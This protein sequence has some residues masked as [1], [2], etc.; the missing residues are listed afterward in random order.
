MHI[1]SYKEAKMAGNKYLLAIA[2][3]LFMPL[4]LLAQWEPDVRLTDDPFESVTSFNNAWCV[5]SSGANVHVVWHDYRDGN[6]EIYYKHSTDNGTNWESD[7]RLTDEASWSERPSIA[8]V[9]SIVH[10]VWYD[11]RLGPP[12]IFYKRSLDN[13]IN[14]GSDISLTPIAGVAYHPSVAVCDSIVHV[15]WT[16]MRAGPQIY[17][18][19]SLDNGTT[20]ETDTIITP[21]A[22]A[23]GKNLASVAVSDSIVHVVWMDMRADPQI[24]YTR[25]LDNG[26][27]WETDRSIS[28]D[29]SQFPSIAVC[30]S[31]VHVVY[32]DFRYGPGSPKIYYLRSLDDGTTWETEIMLADSFASWYPSVAA[33]GPYVHAVWPDSRHGDPSEIYCKRSLDDG[34]NWG[35]DVRLTDNP[36][37]SREPSVAASDSIVHVVWHDDRDG[38][39]E[40]YYKRNPT[41]NT[42][43]IEEENNYASHPYSFFA[44]SFFYD[45]IT[46]RFNR[47]MEAPLKISLYDIRGVQVLSKIYDRIPILLSLEDRGIK[48]L[49][50]GIYFLRVGLDKQ[51]GTQKLIKLK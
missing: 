45:R 16:D 24:Y 11:G 1:K 3:G 13:G 6:N 49:T 48:H 27:T 40:I 22:P 8:V 36:S 4:A 51:T 38:N 29:S 18:T 32:A 25:S 14:W 17:Y 47:S 19:R 44:P 12:R 31:I 35:L 2:V 23:A 21:G 50:P 42:G 33:S 10:V 9:D 34:T 43:I 28:P 39:W 46:V 26:T 7:R 30:D 15:V 41:G 20:W 37:E 5:V